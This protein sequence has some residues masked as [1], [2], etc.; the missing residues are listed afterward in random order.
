MA[1]LL[2]LRRAVGIRII[3]EF[4]DFPLRLSR[5]HLH[6][7]IAN[8]LADPRRQPSPPASLADLLERELPARC[9]HESCIVQPGLSHDSVQRLW[10]QVSGEWFHG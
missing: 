1:N 4:A 8:P 10:P 7:G 3:K 2:R 9:L 6:K 5:Q